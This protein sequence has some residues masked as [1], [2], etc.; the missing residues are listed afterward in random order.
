MP[1]GGEE[2]SEGVQ[3]F[4]PPIGQHLRSPKQHEAEDHLK[5]SIEEIKEEGL[6]LVEEVDSEG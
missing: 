4:S 2:R 5:V 6:L 1:G 3:G